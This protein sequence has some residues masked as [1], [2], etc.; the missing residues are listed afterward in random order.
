MYALFHHLPYAILYFV[1]TCLQELYCFMFS[2]NDWKNLHLILVKIYM[3]SVILRQWNQARKIAHLLL[4][5][6]SVRSRSG[7]AT[8]TI[9]S[10]GKTWR[11]YR[12]DSLDKP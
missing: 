4:V 7:M 1:L 5:S 2:K 10:A 11:G 8:A 3:T 6:T 9:W 12:M